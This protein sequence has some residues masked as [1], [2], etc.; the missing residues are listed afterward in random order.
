M[1]T[2]ALSALATLSLLAISVQ[3]DAH[4]PSVPHAT[5]TITERALAPRATETTSP[6]PLASMTYAA[7]SDLPY[8]VNPYAVGVDFQSR[9]PE[10]LQHRKYPFPL[11]R[12][13]RK[14]R[15]HSCP[16]SQ[17]NSTTENAD[18]EC[19]VAFL[20][21]ISAADLDAPTTSF[22]RD[23]LLSG[24]VEAAVVAYCTQSGH[25][26]RIIPA[27][28]ITGVQYMITDAYVQV[29]GFVN[30]TGI[31]LMSNDTG[32]E[33][34]PHG[35]DQL[36]NPLGGTVWSS[37]IPGASNSSVQQVHNWNMFVG[38]DT[39]CFKACFNNVTSPDYCENRWD[40]LGCNYNAPAA[41]QQNVFEVC[42]G[43]VQDP[44]NTYT[45]A[46][47]KTSTMTTLSDDWN[48][49][50]SWTARI[51]SSSECTTYQSTDLFPATKL[52]YQAPFLLLSLP[53]S[54]NPL[55][56]PSLPQSTGAALA[57][58]S[59]SKSSGSSATASRTTSSAGASNTGSSS[60]AAAA[61]SSTGG[62][63]SLGKTLGAGAVFGA[64]GLVAVLFF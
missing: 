51:P 41:Y 19:Q 4:H 9:S 16:S 31:G 23:R 50:L 56:P 30:N 28:A 43:D 59:L 10:W 21:T 29:V 63:A 17:C 32:G 55:T 39:F 62:A 20:N 42:K 14:F 2:H 60:A 24:D 64:V 3:A 22:L 57:T 58:S 34:D 44:V 7:L 27:G 25:G 18:S 13:L 5:H 54:S 53:L 15:Q 46:D 6:L 61:T 36:G 49:S 12:H 45:G 48:G 8:K 26:T 35:A 11:S 38:S 40:L 33:L 52:G 37:A 1:L 47:G